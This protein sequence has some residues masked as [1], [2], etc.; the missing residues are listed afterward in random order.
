MDHLKLLIVFTGTPRQ[1]MF[2]NTLLFLNVLA[3]STQERL[4]KVRLNVNLVYL[5]TVT[6][7]VQPSNINMMK[8]RMSILTEDVKLTVNV[9]DS[10]P[11]LNLATVL[12]K[13]DLLTTS[14]ILIGM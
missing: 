13:L 1:M 8:L 6:P 4:N 7:Y 9:M 14:I 2:M 10:E 5:M 3:D 12:T 11:V